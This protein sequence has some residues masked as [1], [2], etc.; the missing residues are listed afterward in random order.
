MS[1]M[2]IKASGE[3][4]RSSM[5]C[6]R[7]KTRGGLATATAGCK[8]NAAHKDQSW[9]PP[10]QAVLRSCVTW[11]AS[12]RGSRS[13]GARA[14]RSGLCRPWARFMRPDLVDRI[15]GIPPAPTTSPSSAG[16]SRRS[17]GTDNLE[18]QM[19][20]EVITGAIENAG[21]DRRDIGFTCAGSCDYLT[22]GRSPSSPNLDAA[23]A[24]PPIS[25]R[26]WR[27]TGPGRCTRRGCG[28]STATSTSPSSSDPGK[29][30][31]SNPASSTPSSSTRT[32]SRRWAGPGVDRRAAG[33]GPAR[34]GQ[35]HRARLRRGRRPQPAQRHGQ[36]NAQLCGDVDVD[37]LL[38]EPYVRCAAAPPR[39]PADHRRRRR[40]RPRPRRPGPRAVRAPGVD[41]RASTTAS[42]STSPACGTSPRRRRPRWRR[43]GRARRRPARRGRA[44]GD[45]QPAG[46]A[47]CGEALGLGADVPTST[48]RAARSPPTRSWRP[49]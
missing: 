27:W 16:R 42:R 46:A 43:E 41:P 28:C 13:G 3:R 17:C 26:T 32:T 45:V 30:S 34:R 6:V 49:A 7:A 47:S 44:V 21:I 36:P 25:S 19:L 38:A 33:P 11:R 4:S 37:A 18:A 31:P 1:T 29:S 22:G 39:P 5:R 12:G 48:R 35:G 2:A 20:L 14:R 10:P 15:Q 40:G 9:P 8:T 23:G 24:W